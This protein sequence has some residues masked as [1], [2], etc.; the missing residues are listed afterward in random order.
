MFHVV[1]QSSY[2]KYVALSPPNCAL[3]KNY[4]AVKVESYTDTVLS[5]TDVIP[6]AIMLELFTGVTS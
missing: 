1:S 6:K 4:V 2:Q 3:H 5:C